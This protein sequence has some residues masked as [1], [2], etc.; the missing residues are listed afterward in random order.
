MRS[1]PLAPAP[2]HFREADTGKWLPARVPGCVHRDLIRNGRIPD[3]FWGTNELGQQ[4]IE[5]RDWEY[6]AVF[7]VPEGFLS[8]EDVDLVAEGLDTVA[9]VFLNGTKVLESENMFHSHRVPVRARLR[10][11]RNEIV[12]RFGSAM[13]YI[14]SRRP[15]HQPREFNDPVGR[16]QVIRKEQCQFGWDWAPRLVTCGIWRDIRLEAWSGNRLAGVRIEQI[17]APGGAVSLRVHPD[18]ARAGAPC[19]FRCAVTL[20]G[21]EVAAATGPAGLVLPIPE[22]ALWWPRDHGHQPLYMVAVELL[23]GAGGAVLDSTTRRIGLRTVSLE[24]KPDAWGE[25][26]HFL[27]NGRPIFAKGANWIPA[28]SFVAGLARE[29]YARELRSA[30]EAHM[31]MVRVWGG[32]IYESED[33]YDLCDELGLL[34]WQDFM[35]A[36]TI[37]PGD[38]AFLDSVQREAEDQVRRLRHRACLALWCGNNEIEGLNHQELREKP[39]LRAHYDSLFHQVLPEVVTRLGGGT[40]YWPTS[41]YR[42]PGEATHTFEMGEKRGDTHFWD[43]WHSRKPVKDYEKYLFRFVSEFGMQSF[44]SPATQAAFCPAGDGNIF[45]PA[46]ENH[47]KNA[48]GNKTILDYV[49]ESYRFPKDQASLIYLSQLNQALCMQVGVEH[50]RRTMPRCMGALY[51]QLN[52]CWP[53]ASWSGLE[54][55]GNW[56]ALHHVVRRFFSPALV[57]AHVPGEETRGIGNYRATTVRE[58]HLYTVYDAPEP[59]SGLLSWDL[60]HMDGRRLK[61]GKMRVR[62]GYGE[63]VKQKTLDVT[64][65]MAKHG[66]DNLYLRM[67]LD[68][69]GA[70]ASEGTVFL[71]PPRFLSL[72]KPQTKVVIESLSRTRFRVT[73]LSPVFQHRFGFDLGGLAHS[74]SDNY[75]DLIPGEPRT[76]ELHVEVAIHKSLLRNKLTYRSLADSYA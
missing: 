66:R 47:Q 10:T 53:C 23:D 58:V 61:S 32:G 14:R 8:E 35:F 17:H 68:V 76:V 20:L 30:A 27:V 44:S 6:R 3:P 9:E 72:P 52:D 73:F 71:T 39:E 60:F 75:F 25:S 36:C 50:Y 7:S 57:S 63:S 12:A 56:K 16:S 41:P 18:T 48:G 22:P 31:N 54:F 67:A 11:G 5:G 29:D 70:R 13:A 42:G 40:D 49:A 62:L 33:F 69:G 65:A 43:V 15:E 21:T 19:T 59:A 74:S 64:R 24:R 1:L 34:V 2:W 37:Y 38:R 28:H 45:G 46:M 51:W 4:W 55:N 26:F